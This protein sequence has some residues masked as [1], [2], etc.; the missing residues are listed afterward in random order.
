MINHGMPVD[1]IS[2]E[3]PPVKVRHWVYL[4]FTNPATYILQSSL[5]CNVCLH[6]FFPFLGCSLSHT[7]ISA[8]QKGKERREKATF[9]LF[10]LSISLYKFLKLFSEEREFR[11]ETSAFNRKSGLWSLRVF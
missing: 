11:I 4:I 10:S 5:N 3:Q 8:E 7:L 9:S 2:I 1:M 6:V